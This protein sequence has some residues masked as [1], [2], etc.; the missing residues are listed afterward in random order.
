MQIGRCDQCVY[1]ERPRRE[2]ASLQAEHRAAKSDDSPAADVAVKAHS[3]SKKSLE[4]DAH[5]EHADWAIKQFDCQEGL[6]HAVELW[7]QAKTEHCCKH[8]NVGCD[9]MPTQEPLSAYEE[10]LKAMDD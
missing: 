9:A 1:C 8:E 7:S 2:V 6:E 3:A 5:I 10:F 4:K